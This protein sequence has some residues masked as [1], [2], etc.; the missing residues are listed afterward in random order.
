[1]SDKATEKTFTLKEVMEAV[2]SCSDHLRGMTILDV[3][4]FR[5]KLL[6]I[7]P[8]QPKTRKPPIR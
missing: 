2:E 7:E 6:G 3:P 8:Q 4:K 5:N 1:M